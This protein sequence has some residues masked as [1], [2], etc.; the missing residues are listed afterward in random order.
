[1]G[2]PLKKFIRNKQI[3]RK[4][5]KVKTITETDYKTSEII[6]VEVDIGKEIIYIKIVSILIIW[7]GILIIT[8]KT[9]WRLSSLIIKSNL[10]KLK[11][12]LTTIVIATIRNR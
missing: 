9:F 12:K 8:A 1:M 4:Y 6:I 2:T 11:L 10:S 3:L 7:V 5:K